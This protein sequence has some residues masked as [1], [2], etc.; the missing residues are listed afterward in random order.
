MS[1]SCVRRI[2]MSIATISFS[3]IA[4]IYLAITTL[5]TTHTW[6]LTTHNASQCYRKISLSASTYLYC[7]GLFFECAV[8][9]ET[10][11]ISQQ[12]SKMSSSFSLLLN[13]KKDQNI[14]RCRLKCLP[15]KLTNQIQ[16]KLTSQWNWCRW[17]K[18]SLSFFL[19]RFGKRCSNSFRVQSYK[20]SENDEGDM[21]WR[22]LSEKER[23]RLVTLAWR[24][25]WMRENEK[26]NSETQRNAT[27]HN[28]HY[29]WIEQ[30]V[31]IHMCVSHSLR[32]CVRA[33]V[34]V[35]MSLCAC[36]CAYCV[37]RFVSMSA[38]VCSHCCRCC[39]CYCFVNEKEKNGYS[40]NRV[41]R[42]H[43]SDWC[44]TCAPNSIYDEFVPSRRFSSKNKNIYKNYLYFFFWC[45]VLLFRLVFSV[46]NIKRNCGIFCLQFSLDFK[47]RRK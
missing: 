1:L 46:W 7:S 19:F 43:R 38:I 33:C 18:H 5:R 23:M 24:C 37:L 45:C 30:L 44:R 6:T 41:T 12:L 26:E 21:K 31:Y 15:F 35:C 11:E 25:R 34:H 36:L 13:K 47:R 39:R 17:A 29:G 22:N 4:S 20:V 42:V 9:N 2:R 3:C 28:M 14:C 40:S 10:E 16:N 8:S 27:Q 32:P